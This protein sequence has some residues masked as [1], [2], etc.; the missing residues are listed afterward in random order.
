MRVSSWSQKTK[1]IIKTS[2]S[3]LQFDNL[4][5]WLSMNMKSIKLKQ[6][7]CQSGTGGC[8]FIFIKFKA[9]YFICGKFRKHRSVS[10]P[11]EVG[12][13]AS[14]WP[15]GGPSKTRSCHRIRLNR[16]CSACCRNV[17]IPAADGLFGSDHDYYRLGWI[18]SVE[19]RTSWRVTVFGYELDLMRMSQE[20]KN[21][22]KEQVSWYKDIRKFVQY[23]SLHRLK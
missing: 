1:L 2:N 10:H 23:G 11:S 22:V 16:R 17:C 7:P 13:T 9:L 12:R 18:W 5:C 6:P 4:L 8:F 20:D 15:V 19:A 3:E 14:S 21:K